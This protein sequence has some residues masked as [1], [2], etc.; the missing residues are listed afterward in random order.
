MKSRHAILFLFALIAVAVF[1]V[2]I[3]TREEV[4]VYIYHRGDGSP[5]YIGVSNAPERRWQQHER[6]NK[7]FAHLHPRVL[8]CYNSRRAAVAE[9]KRLIQKHC[10]LDNLYNKRGC[11]E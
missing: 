7:P 8:R 9:E 3:A 10:K 4:C 1:A 5:A 6:D 2:Y 11:T